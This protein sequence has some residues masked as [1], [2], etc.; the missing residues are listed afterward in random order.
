MLAIVFGFF[1]SRVISRP[2]RNLAS[3][4]DKL[5]L[6]DVNV[7][8]ETTTRDEVGILSQSF[9]K[10]IENIRDASRAAEKIAPGDMK[11]ELKVRSE[12][13]LLGKGLNSMLDTVR[14]IL[15]ETKNLSKAVQDW[16]ARCTRRRSH[17]QRGME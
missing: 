8:I 16:K 15:S 1:I 9:K 14:K 5:A 12:N 4:V 3:A 17:V 2:I 10:V 6:G 7:S 11:V 13:D